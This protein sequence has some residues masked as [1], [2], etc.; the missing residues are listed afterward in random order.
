MLTDAEDAIN[1]L[2]VETFKER[3]EDYSLFTNTIV[4]CDQL[5]KSIEQAAEP[6]T[7]NLPKLEAWQIDAYAKQLCPALDDANIAWL[8]STT[9]CD[10]NRVINELSKVSVFDKALQKD[11]FSALQFD[12]QHEMY[13]VDIFNI[14]NALIDGDMPTLYDLIKHSDQL[15]IEPVV[16]A[17]RATTSLKNIILVSQNPELSAEDCGVSAGQRNVLKYKYRSL[18][19]E[20]AKHKLKFLAEFDLKL[21]TSKLD[22]SKRDMLSYLLSNLCYKITL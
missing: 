14:V 12:I 22:L 7:I 16:L 19:V 11:I 21:K 5:D 20:A 18:N 9:K 13:E 3:A 4:V 8:T 15:N 6:F 17:N 10:I 2:Y 1:I